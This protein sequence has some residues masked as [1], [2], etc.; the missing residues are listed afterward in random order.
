MVNFHYITKEN[1]KEHNRNWPKIPGH[2]YRIF[3]KQVT[4]KG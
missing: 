2:P 1:M 3:I 4:K